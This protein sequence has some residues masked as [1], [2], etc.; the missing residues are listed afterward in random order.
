METIKVEEIIT[1]PSYF[2]HDWMALSVGNEEKYNAMTIAWGQI[3]SVWDKYDTKMHDIFPV[4]TVYVRPSRY[5]KE[6]MDSQETFALNYFKAEQRKALGILG[7]K[8]GRNTDKIKLA[9]LTPCFENNTM[10]FQEAKLVILCRKIYQQ[11]LS[12]DGFIDSKIVERNYPLKDFHT[13]YVGEIIQV[14]SI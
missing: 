7:S 11:E 8:S 10:F 12:E 14:M 13:M 1:K 5:T 2:G 9:G 4:A 6:F 3:G